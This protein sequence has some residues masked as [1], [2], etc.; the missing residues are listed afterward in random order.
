MCDTLDFNR[1][2]NRKVHIKIQVNLLNKVNNLCVNKYEKSIRNIMKNAHI[3][4]QW[5]IFNIPLSEVS[6]N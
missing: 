4:N 1:K 5:E 2:I 3:Q 6:R